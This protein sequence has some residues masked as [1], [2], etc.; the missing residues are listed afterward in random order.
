MKDSKII[1]KLLID[2]GSDRDTTEELEA[3]NRLQKHSF[4]SSCLSIGHVLWP[5]V[6]FIIVLLLINSNNKIAKNAEELHVQAMALTRAT[7]QQHTLWMQEIYR[8]RDSLYTAH[9]IWEDSVG[10]K[11]DATMHLL[12]GC[13]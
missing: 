12:G 3:L 6:A 1:R 2:V 10:I 5:I 8:E 4:V 7:M 9:Q 11:Y 13:E